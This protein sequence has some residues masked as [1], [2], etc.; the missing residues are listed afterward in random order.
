MYWK[1]TPTW[2]TTPRT[3]KEFVKKVTVYNQETTESYNRSWNK[4]EE[5][6]GLTATEIALFYSKVEN[7]E[8]VSFP[9]PKSL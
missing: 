6:E 9:K 5:E 2:K 3:W 8:A 7:L 1:P 4:V